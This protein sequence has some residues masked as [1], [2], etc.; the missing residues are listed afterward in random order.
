[1][2]CSHYSKR[3][4]LRLLLLHLQDSLL[5]GNGGIHLDSH[6]PRNVDFQDFLTFRQLR[7][8]LD[9]YYAGHVD[10]RIPEQG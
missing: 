8:H 9:S 4:G 3:V 7:A 1:M 10:L 6:Y 5:C 2:T